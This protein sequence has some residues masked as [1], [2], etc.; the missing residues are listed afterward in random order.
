LREL[1][2]RVGRQG[3]TFLRLPERILRKYRRMLV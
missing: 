1:D 3:A 2:F